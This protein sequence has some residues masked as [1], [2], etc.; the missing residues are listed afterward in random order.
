[1]TIVLDLPL[2]DRQVIEIPD[3]MRALSWPLR[4]TPASLMQCG[5]AE[6][7]IARPTGDFIYELSEAGVSAMEVWR[8]D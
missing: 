2:G 7:R 1:M 8:L 3:G 6:I 5:E 4:V